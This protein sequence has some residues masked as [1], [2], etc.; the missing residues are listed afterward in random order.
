VTHLQGVWVSETDGTTSAQAALVPLCRAANWDSSVSR[1]AH[2]R[3]LV[4]SPLDGA[5]RPFVATDESRAR[6]DSW[7]AIAPDTR[8]V[9][10]TQAGE[11]W[12]TQALEDGEVPYEGTEFGGDEPELNL[13]A[14]W[15]ERQ[16][17]IVQPRPPAKTSG[18]PFSDLARKR[19]N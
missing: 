7:I 11:R 8:V 14:L 10:T 18:G 13:L 9:E 12:K 4:A 19:K 17:N 16:A 3:G 5:T 1:Y 15:C 2:L 6:I